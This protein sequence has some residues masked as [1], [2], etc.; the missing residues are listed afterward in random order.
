MTNYKSQ[1]KLFLEGK[2][3][4]HLCK[5]IKPL[6]EFYKSSQH[7]DGYLGN[8]KKCRKAKWKE[9]TV[10]NRDKIREYQYKY[11]KAKELKAVK[12]GIG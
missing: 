1:H 11:R 9:Y 8:C 6:T 10:K 2:R 7:K 12:N 4:C 3:Y 5:E